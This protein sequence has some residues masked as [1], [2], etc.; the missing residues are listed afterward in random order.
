MN[1]H[2]DLVSLIQ[3]TALFNDVA[4]NVL[5]IIL[6]TTRIVRAQKGAH[7]FLKGARPKGFYYIVYGQVKTSFAS[8]NDK[9]KVLQVL[10]ANQFVGEIAALLGSEYPVDAQ[11]TTDSFLIHVGIDAVKYCLSIDPAFAMKF[12]RYLAF[13]NIELMTD[14]ESFCYFNTKERVAKYL[15]D[16]FNKAHIEGNEGEVFFPTSKGVIA[17]KLNLKAETLSRALHYLTNIQLISIKGRSIFIHDKLGL[18]NFLLS[19][20][21][22]EKEQP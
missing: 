1:H 17:S 5:S 18:E 22:T 20:Q 11:C 15:L 21:F 7:L 13:K 3:N 14:I 16:L 4:E 9:G 19:E 2:L 12:I 6:P 10:G 8:P